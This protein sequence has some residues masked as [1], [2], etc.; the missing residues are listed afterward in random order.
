MHR[1]TLL[2][3]GAAATVTTAVLA[4]AACSGGDEPK[5]TTTPTPTASAPT[6][7]E[8]TARPNLIFAPD[9]AY[10][11]DI[12]KAPVAKDSAAQIKNLMGQITP[13]Y[14]GH[15]AFNAHQFN[16]S[17]F[18][19]DAK[20]PKVRVRYTDCQ[21]NGLSPDIYGGKK[22]F[23]DV[24]IPENA[25]PSTGT[26]KALTIYSPATDQLWEF[27]IAEKGKKRGQWS[28]CWG[29]RIDN[30][31]TSR[32]AT[33]TYPYGTSA[34]GIATVATTISIAEAQALKIDHAV[35]LFLIQTRKGVAY[36]PANRNDGQYSGKGAIAFG[37]RLR[38][39][40]SVDVEKLDMPPLAKAI[41]RAAQ[42]YGFM[43]NETSGAVAVGAESP[44]R[45]MSTGKPDPWPAIYRGVQEYDILKDFPWSKLQVVEPG[46]GAPAGVQKVL[47]Q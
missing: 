10:R 18:V 16:S 3:L 42:K 5:P 47:T 14:S 37:T 12:S 25:K 40:A 44:N 4:S 34:S 29:G 26:D 30:A 9:N 38:L 21:G 39:P 43:V 22:Y 13:N 24:P 8:R 31:S 1:S 45:I 6:V 36:Y 23:V 35:Q 27:W 20:T 17:M 15:V 2:R 41:A 32:T 28:A 19:A 7:A 33:F 11:L 46:Y